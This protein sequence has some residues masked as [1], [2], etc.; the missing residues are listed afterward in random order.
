[1]NSFEQ[2]EH[3]SNDGMKENFV[4]VKRGTSRPFLSPI[5]NPSQQHDLEVQ[6]LYFIMANGSQVNF[7]SLQYGTS[8]AYC[9]VYHLNKH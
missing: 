6:Q 2:A 4:A 5:Y 8:H 3:H 7:S 9:V 1:M